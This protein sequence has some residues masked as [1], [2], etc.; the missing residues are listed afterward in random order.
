MIHGATARRESAIRISVETRT[1]APTHA[2]PGS[3]AARARRLLAAKARF[4]QGLAELG[5]LGGAGCDAD[6]GGGVRDLARERVLDGRASGCLL[7]RCGVERCD[8]VEAVLR[9]D[10]GA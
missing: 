4:A 7:D 9:F 10:V 3:S 8:P 5:R 6:L 2:Q 1:S